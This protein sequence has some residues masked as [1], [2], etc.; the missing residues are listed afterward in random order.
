M[1]IIEPT[2]RLIWVTPNAEKVI[3]EGAHLCYK[4]D[5]AITET[6]YIAH[7]QD[8]IRKRRFNMLGFA[9]ACVHVICDRGVTHEIVRHR[10]CT[11]AQE[12]T[13]YCNYGKGEF[14]SEITVV[15]PP[16]LSEH[17]HSGWETACNTTESA[18]LGTLSDGYKPQIARSVLP[19]CLKTEIWWKTN[20]QEWRHIFFQRLAPDAH[21]QMRQIAA[22]IFDLIYEHAPNVFVDFKELRDTIK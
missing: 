8:I 11:F 18:Y 9:D 22:M 6:S 19:T 17:A 14:C 3:E 12:S 15:E 2:V 13:R 16:G 1:K 21:P 20:F 7:I 4:S 5:K 10:I